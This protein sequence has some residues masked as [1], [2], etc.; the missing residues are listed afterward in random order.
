MNI[1]Q[2][3]RARRKTEELEARVAQVEATTARIAHLEEQMAEV[4]EALPKIKGT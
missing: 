1:E 2:E 3:R 4:L